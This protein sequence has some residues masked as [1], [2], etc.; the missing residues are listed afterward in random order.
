MTGGQVKV[1]TAS[2]AKDAVPGIMATVKD[3]VSKA[4]DAEAV[5]CRNGVA[6]LASARDAPAPGVVATA[7]EVAQRH[8]AWT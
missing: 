1:E 5:V 8:Q 6:D 2:R 7:N 4:K 3:A